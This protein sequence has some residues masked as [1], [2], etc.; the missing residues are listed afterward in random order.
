MSR[1]LSF[2][3]ALAVALVG[4]VAIVSPAH[5]TTTTI[6]IDCN[7]QLRGGDYYVRD[8]VVINT[9]NCDYIEQGTN[10]N[11]L[12]TIV[13]SNNQNVTSGVTLSTTNLSTPQLLNFNGSNSTQV[14]IRFLAADSTGNRTSVGQ[15]TLSST[16]IISLPSI[17]P[18]RFTSTSAQANNL[19]V[20]GCDLNYVSHP[21]QVQS[22]TTVASGNLTFR[23][24]A[25][26]PDTSINAMSLMLSNKSYP[27]RD[28][29]LMVYSGQFDP[30]APESGLIACN[31]D[32]GLNA[33]SFLDDGT[34]L[35]GNWPQ[36][37]TSLQPGAYT[38]VL[39][40]KNE[41]AD[42]NTVSGGLSQSA[43]VQ[44]WGPAGAFSTVTNPSNPNS[45]NNSNNN[46][47]NNSISS[48]SNNSNS[49]NN[50]SSAPSNPSNTDTTTASATDASTSLALTG[51]NTGLALSL[52]SLAGVSLLAGAA[53]TIFRNR[54]RS[55][56]QHNA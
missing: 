35:H 24:S 45:S 20:A 42:W 43:S 16:E 34:F 14:A 55:K 4:L 28:M 36:V 38:L 17:N 48:N 31:D 21:Y 47:S 27:V 18:A 53:L 2:F 33:G 41:I 8:S 1:I 51:Y 50:S 11:Y 30:T 5:A 46:N 19:V 12:N 13:D 26:S 49:Q 22:F 6:A 29:M 56:E 39:T 25:T 7:Q 52:V 9:T 23:V 54:I 15:L 40:N 44:F 3:A 10:S 32:S 37:T